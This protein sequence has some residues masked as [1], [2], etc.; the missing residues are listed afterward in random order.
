MKKYKY[1]L[2]EWA[3]LILVSALIVAVICL[4]F[5]IDPRYPY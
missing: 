4:L 1:T 3:A 5:S 2:V